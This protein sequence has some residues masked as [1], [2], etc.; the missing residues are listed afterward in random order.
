MNVRLCPSNETSNVPG[1][2][3]FG[4][5]SMTVDSSLMFMAYPLVEAARYN[6]TL[7]PVPQQRDPYFGPSGI[8]NPSSNLPRAHSL[9]LSD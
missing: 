3:N 5:N 4:P 6:P 8:T 7:P 2:L 9:G 1:A